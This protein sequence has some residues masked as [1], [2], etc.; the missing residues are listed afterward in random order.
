MENINRDGHKLLFK[1][2]EFRMGQLL[3]QVNTA[4]PIEVKL[5][6]LNLVGLNKLATDDEEA[7]RLIA[8]HVP[9]LP[10][11][12]EQFVLFYK[13][14]GK[15]TVLLGHIKVRE[16]LE[17]GSTVLRGKL[18]SGPGLKKCRIDKPEPVAIVAPPPAPTPQFSA[19]R[20]DDRRRSSTTNTDRR[21]TAPR[22]GLENSRPYSDR[23]QRAT[24][25]TSNNRTTTRGDFR[26]S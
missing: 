5:D 18:I 16:A 6:E 20:F 23:P 10:E 14:E 4:P 9:V 22:R 24:S 2:E 17:A 13:Q 21:D 26:K 3:A 8:K 25:P 15:F 19:P 1:G 11:Y 7:K 12:L